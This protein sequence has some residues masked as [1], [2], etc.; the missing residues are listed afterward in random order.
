MKLRCCCYYTGSIS[1]RLFSSC[2][3]TK[4]TQLNFLTLSPLF[5]RCFGSA[6]VM[7]LI[8]STLLI[9]CWNYFKSTVLL[10]RNKNN[11][12]G[13]QKT[14]VQSQ[15]GI[16]ISHQNL[17]FFI[18]MTTWVSNQTK[19]PRH[20]KSFKCIIWP[21]NVLFLDVLDGMETLKSHE[22]M[23]WKCK[24]MNQISPIYSAIDILR[25]TPK[26]SV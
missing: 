9:K 21:T 16:K 17:S 23:L 13:T 4:N 22:K 3:I 26:T 8:R 18:L 2:V 7:Q 24:R 12:I 5:I 20:Q 15:I 25:S 6:I 19:I 1:S 11:N 14:S 10:H